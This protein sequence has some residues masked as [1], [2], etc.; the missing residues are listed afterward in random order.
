MPISNFIPLLLLALLG[1]LNL[2]GIR[3]DL[4]LQ[5][6]IQFGLGALIF[7]IIK[8]FQLHLH[9]LRQNATVLYIISIA[10]LI[11]T[12]IL[13]IEVKGSKRWIDLY[14]FQIQF[15]EVF[16]IFFIVIMAKLFSYATTPVENS[17]LVVKAI[18]YSFV[19]IIAI[20]FQ[21][22]LGTTIVIVSIFIV[23]LLHSRAPKKHILALALLVLVALPIVWFMMKDYQKIRLTSFFNQSENISGYSYNI[24]QAKIA[25]GSGTLFG[26]GLG[27]GKQ[28]SLHFL[29]EYHTDFA[30]ASL[31]EQFG[32]IGGALILVFFALFIFLSINRMNRHIQSKDISERYSFFYLLGFNTLICTHVFIN[33]GMNLGIFPV[34][35]ITLPFISYGGSS[36]ITFIIGLALIP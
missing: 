23:M 25:I 4:V 35:G 30:Y 10:F 15:S 3:Q 34:T 2:T 6:L 20:F 32:F 16:K 9:F 13:G 28:A 36:L 27:M 11:V 24:E 12:F 7:F 29:P 17:Q 8:F 5:Y 18:L 19:P 14:L 26:R 22:D 31:V 21:P 33:I 1:L